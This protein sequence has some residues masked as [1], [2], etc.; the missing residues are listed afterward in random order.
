MTPSM[1]RDASKAS[2]T[3]LSGPRPLGNMGQRFLHPDH[4]LRV[5]PRRAVCTACYPF[6]RIEWA[7]QDSEALQNLNL[8]PSAV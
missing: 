7:L 3:S 6:R 8:R 5:C 4:Q 1:L 2:A